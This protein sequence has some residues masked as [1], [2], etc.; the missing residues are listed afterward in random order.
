[1][2]PEAMTTL[3]ASGAGALVAAMATDVWQG[4][5]GGAVRLYRRWNG[6]RNATLE[7]QL[8]QHA[9]LVRQADDPD[10]ARQLLSG[11]WQLLFA[12][13]L[14][15]HPDAE[16]DLRALVETIRREL[17][18]SGKQWV[19][20]NIA[21]DQGTVYGVQG[22]NVIHHHQGLPAAPGSAGEDGRQQ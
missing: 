5:R 6:D 13:L 1:M 8:D 7:A 20:T 10:R 2:L 4:A 3:A 21:R 12:Q 15:E 17:P 18:E 19:Q 22:G 11:Q 16:A 14:S 9:L